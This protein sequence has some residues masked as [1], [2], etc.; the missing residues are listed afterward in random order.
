MLVDTSFLYGSGRRGPRRY[1]PDWD[2]GRSDDELLIS[3]L[4]YPEVQVRSA[5]PRAPRKGYTYSY[6][7]RAFVVSSLLINAS[8][9]GWS[10]MA[11]PLTTLSEI[12]RTTVAV[13]YGCSRSAMR[14]GASGVCLQSSG[15]GGHLS[16]LPYCNLGGISN[17]RLGQTWR[18]KVS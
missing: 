8:S 9:R 12:L 17:S 6:M 2:R 16:T 11:S 15:A 3:F 18:F 1:A 4:Q 7:Y 14:C 5:V 10:I 13:P